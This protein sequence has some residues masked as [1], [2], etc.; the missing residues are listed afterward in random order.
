MHKIMI[1]KFYL[2]PKFGT[3]INNKWITISELLHSSWIVMALP[4][5]FN[6]ATAVSES[7]GQNHHTIWRRAP[8]AESSTTAPS[9]TTK[10]HGNWPP[11]PSPSLPTPRR[12]AASMARCRHAARNH[13]PRS[14]SPP[15]PRR[16]GTDPDLQAAATGAPPRSRGRSTSSG[17]DVLTSRPPPTTQ[18]QPAK[19]RPA[20]SCCTTTA[21]QGRPMRRTHAPHPRTPCR[22]APC[23]RAPCRR[24]PCRR[25]AG[26]PTIEPRLARAAAP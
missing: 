22:R 1:K 25:R 10:H 5:H 17:V 6:A 23:R 3:L 14:W 26:H 20:G 24:A 2:S 4:Q 15:R 8:A 9:G 18:P 16:P 19:D 13:G 7:T 11:L 12:Q 21:G